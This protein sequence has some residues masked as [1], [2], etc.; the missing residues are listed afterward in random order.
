VRHC[1]SEG[2]G[3][4]GAPPLIGRQPVWGRQYLIVR[5]KLRHWAPPY[6][7]SMEA[8]F[9]ETVLGALFPAQAGEALRAEP[10]PAPGGGWFEDYGVSEEELA[11]AVRRMRERNRAPGPDGV[12]GRTW[13]LALKLVGDRIR[14]LFDGCLREG[15]FPPVWR[16]AKLVLLRKGS[17]PADVPA[18]Y[19][20]ICLLDE[21]AKLL[22]R[23]I[24]GRLVQHLEQ[25]GPDLHERQYGFRRGRSTMDAILHVRSLADSAVQEGGVAVGVSLDITNAFNT[26]PWDRI[27]RALEEHQVPPYLR[28]ILQDYLSDRWLEYGGQ[29]GT[30]VLRRVCRGVPQGS[31][32]G[33]HLWNLGY[34]FVLRHVLL[35]S[36]CSVVCYADDTVVIAAE[37]DWG[38]AR[39]RASE[40]IANVVRNI[41]EFGFGIAPQKTEAMYFHKGRQ[42]A[43]PEDG[44]EVAGVLVP[45]GARMK[46][47]GLMLDSKWA[48]TTHFEELAPRVGKAADGLGRLLPNIGGPGGG[49]ADYIWGW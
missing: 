11:G 8:P 31:V 1:E 3:L 16:R 15:I 44:I 18:G 5:E 4:G 13:A 14:R 41:R 40:A 33:P 26:L 47:L 46:Y 34:D 9:L 22:E 32:L 28:R 35:P 6:T 42:G 27:G 37:G 17:K 45:I 48:F 19:R 39:S 7:E 30:P 20:P 2:H 38:E 49:F 43:P 21:V 29:H 12:P 25:V 10:L 23:V 24:A 36:G